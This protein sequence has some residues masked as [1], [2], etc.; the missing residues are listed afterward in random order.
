MAQHN[1]ISD[2]PLSTEDLIAKDVGARLPTGIM[3]KVIT[4]LAISWS[5]F[6]LWIASPLPFIIGI[7]VFNDT[8][9]RAIHLAFALILA[10]LVFPARQ[11][12]ATDRVPYSDIALG[13]IAAATSLYLFVMY[14]ELAQRPGSLTQLDQFIHLLLT[15]YPITVNSWFTTAPNNIIFF[16]H[17]FLHTLFNIVLLVQ[18]NIQTWYSKILPLMYL[19]DYAKINITIKKYSY[20]PSIVF[21]NQ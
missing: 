14:H 2:N 4:L 17:H 7:G 13:M 16:G 21:P 6:Q 1:L 20:S 15:T 3:A 12:S 9:T 10:F 8:E 5:L 18:A 11:S 19:S